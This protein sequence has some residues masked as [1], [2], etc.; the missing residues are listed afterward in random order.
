MDL[1]ILIEA[2]Q[3]YSFLYDLSNPEY[4]N[5]K[6]KADAWAEIAQILNGSVDD[7]IRA[8]KNIR[9]KFVKEQKKEKTGSGAKPIWR[10]YDAM[11]FYAK[12]TKKRTTYC[13][14]GP[15]K[16]KVKAT[17]S[18]PSSASSGWSGMDT[19][20]SLPS[21]PL[22]TGANEDEHIHTPST[23]KGSGRKKSQTDVL[24]EVMATAKEICGK[25][26]RENTDST[27]ANKKFTEY[28][29]ARLEEMSAEEARQKRKD[30][31]LILED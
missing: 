5:S 31:L 7:C 25:M 10:Y 13:S 30:M 22:S 12:Y 29:F 9:D 18:R 14:T 28:A 11:L 3:N 27:N 20:I 1:G 17:S 16:K 8:W 24:N 19:N 26:T 2:V 15:T 23:S 6:K 21:S 4:K